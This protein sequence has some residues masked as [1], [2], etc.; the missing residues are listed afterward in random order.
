MVASPAGS[1]IIA[2]ATAR[3]GLYFRMIREGEAQAGER[4][5]LL[6]RPLPDWPIARV[7]RLLIGGGHKANRDAVA[8]LADMPVLAE[9]WR[10]RA[11]HLAA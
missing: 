1:S 3:C 8:Q 11:R 2:S 7:F 6:D 4:M 5:T 10:E 9:A